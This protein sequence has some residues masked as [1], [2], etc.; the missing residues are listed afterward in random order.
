[1]YGGDR[2]GEV[3][4]SGGALR[5][6]VCAR[7]GTMVDVK[8]AVRVALTYAQDV[9]GRPGP[10]VDEIEREEYKGREVWKITL[11]FSQTA[12]HALT[13]VPNTQ[14]RSIF[15][16]AETGDPLAVKIRELTT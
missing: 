13:G 15:V 12:W 8:Q 10:T 9:L 6:A 1:M 16:D 14:F 4:R 5:T 2:G 3:F 7:F 11:G